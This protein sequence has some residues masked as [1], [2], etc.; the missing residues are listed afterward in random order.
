MEINE[1]VS[2]SSPEQVKGM[3]DEVGD[4]LKILE[5]KLTQAFKDSN[6][7]SI[8]ELIVEYQFYTNVLNRLKMKLV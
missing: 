4:K 1:K 2:E 6:Y 3:I 8:K 5:D 7:E